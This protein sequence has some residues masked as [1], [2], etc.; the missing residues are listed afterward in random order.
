MF[1]GKKVSPVLPYYDISNDSQI[2]EEISKGNGRISLSGVQ[3]KYSMVVENGV[4]RFAKEGEQGTYILK[5]SPTANFIM[6]KEY[7][8]INEFLTMHI[9]EIF[10]IETAIN[11]LCYFG[12]GKVA[13]IT[14]RFDIDK[15]GN[16]FAQEDFGALAG[17]NKNNAGSDYKY[18]ALSYED[19]ADII[20]MNVKASMV[21]LLKFYKLVIFNY[22][23]LNDDA[24][25]KNFSLVERN[26]GDYVL[27]P[28]YD[29]MNTSLHLYKPSI[30]AL[31]K[32]L[33]K[34]GMILDD[35]HGVNR[36]SFVEFG[37][38]IGLNKKVINKELDRFSAEYSDIEELVTNSGLSEKLC[39]DYLLSYKYRK[40]TLC[41]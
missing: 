1:D 22:L 39:K 29:L 34:E 8:P 12:N 30:F 38:R 24:H 27:S 40:S 6:D 9:A 7:C 26:T 16:K 41:C 4:I 13:Y 20:K 32:G 31:Q 25:I 18:S 33:F 14:K 11:A 35:T 21:E 10:N 15:D 36:N 19:C 2:I 5:P 37:N 23:F 3:P 17:L 28:A